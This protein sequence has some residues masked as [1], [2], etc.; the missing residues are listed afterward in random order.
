M[1]RPWTAEQRA[2]QSALVHTWK[3]WEKS[4]GPKT[5]EGKAIVSQ[6]NYKGNVRGMLKEMKGV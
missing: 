4:T 5:A 1:E 3:R 6:N 2:R